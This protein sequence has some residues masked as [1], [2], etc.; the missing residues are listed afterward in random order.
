[1]NK[2]ISGIKPFILHTFLFCLVFLLSGC[3]QLLNWNHA[4]EMP[5]PAWHFAVD[6]FTG[7]VQSGPRLTETTQIDPST[8]S[9]VKVTWIG[10]THTPTELLFPVQT[11]IQ[12]IIT[13][14]ESKLVRPVAQFI[15]NARF[16][17]IEDANALQAEL[18]GADQKLG[19]V[20]GSLTGAL[21]MG[22]CCQFMVTPD[23][24]TS[25]QT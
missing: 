6:H 22:A 14:P 7:T 15:Q 1:M 21:P 4:A 5:R 10:L 12:R 23:N 25:S 17:A 18:C 16:S 20:L 24:V 19:T 2:S 9:L 3:V 11:H 8:T 13:L